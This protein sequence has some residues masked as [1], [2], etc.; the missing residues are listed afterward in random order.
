M[1]MSMAMDEDDNDFK[2]DNEEMLQMRFCAIL[3]GLT[4]DKGLEC[5]TMICEHSAS[6]C[7]PARQA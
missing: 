5:L 3:N 2:M 4:T 7:L 6:A 1:S